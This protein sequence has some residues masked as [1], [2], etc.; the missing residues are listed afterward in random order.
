MNFNFY[1][2]ANTKPIKGGG[3][4]KKKGLENYFLCL[5]FSLE[6]EGKL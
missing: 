4:K 1:S 2:K 6:R 5:R 3:M